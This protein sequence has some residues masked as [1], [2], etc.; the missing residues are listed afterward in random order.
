MLFGFDMGTTSKLSKEC[1]LGRGN[2]QLPG[3]LDWFSKF[4]HFDSKVMD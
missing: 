2:P 4:F 3:I 1:G